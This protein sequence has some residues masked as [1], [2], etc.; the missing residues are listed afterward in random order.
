MFGEVQY[1]AEPEES[2]NERTTCACE[3]AHSST[4]TRTHSSNLFTTLLKFATTEPTK[5]VRISLSCL[6]PS[7]GF[8]LF[9]FPGQRKMSSGEIIQNTPGA[10]ALQDT[11]QADLVSRGYASEGDEVMVRFL[12]FAAKWYSLAHNCVL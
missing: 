11:I 3:N 1:E 12:C 2:S 8:S 9:N 4:K 5:P 7:Q 10:K 6:V